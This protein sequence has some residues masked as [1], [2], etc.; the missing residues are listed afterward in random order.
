[1]FHVICPDPLVLYAFMGS[2][3]CIYSV[4]TSRPFFV[5]VCVP[6]YRG[7]DRAYLDCITDHGG[8]P[9]LCANSEE[10]H[11]FYRAAGFASVFCSHNAFLDWEIYQPLSGLR[12]YDFVINS[13]LLPYKRHSLIPAGYHFAMIS[14]PGRDELAWEPFRPAWK[15]D[16]YLAAEAVNEIYA[17][18][19]LGLILSATE[20]ACWSSTEYL[21]AGLP[22]ISTPAKGGR[23][24]FYNPLNSLICEPTI[25]S[26]QCSVNDALQR[27]WDR[28][29]IRN[30]CIE[31]MK[32]HRMRFCRH[33]SQ[34]A[35]IDGVEQ[36]KMTFTNRLLRWFGSDDEARQYI[37]KFTAIP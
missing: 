1:M 12:R 21:L 2:H 18:S 8:Y 37:Q 36:L 23:E 16:K 5:Y 34:L 15:N 3:P 35:G 27:Q 4:P 6:W 33:L 32:E 17:Q 9:I 24:I 14:Q 22:V 10:E 19:K 13:V 29:Q 26:V 30:D 31:L 25:Q 20:G 11:D 28:D 7:I